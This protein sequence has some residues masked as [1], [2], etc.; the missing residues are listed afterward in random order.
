MLQNLPFCITGAETMKSALDGTTLS[1]QHPKVYLSD[2][3]V[4]EKR[5]Q[6]GLTLLPRLECSGTITAHCS[7]NFPG[8]SNPPIL[9]SRLLWTTGMSQMGF[10]HVAQAGLEFLGSSYSPSSSSQSAVIIGMNHRAPSSCFLCTISEI[11]QCSVSKP[12][13]FAL[14]SL[15]HFEESTLECSG[16]IIAHCSLNLQGSGDP[17]TSASQVVGTTGLC[18]QAW[19]IFEF[20]VETGSH[21]A[22]QAGLKLLGSSNPPTSAS[23][24][25][26]I[27]RHEPLNPSTQHE[28]VRMKTFIMTYFHSMNIDLKNLAL[29]PRLEFSGTILAHCN[30]HLPGSSNSTAS[31]SQDLTNT[32]Q[33]KCVQEFQRAFQLLRNVPTLGYRRSEDN[34]RRPHLPLLSLVPRL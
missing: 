1:K 7:L 17:P 24:R 11:Q 13:T 16:I 33:Y 20:F 9:A 23:K 18:Y 30:L 8:S 14:A 15:F 12:L 34:L 6:A 19:L 32:F 5:Q 27:I 10:Q 28:D 21:H 25:A 26:K 2:E 29:S 4:E 31:A 22:A 3:E